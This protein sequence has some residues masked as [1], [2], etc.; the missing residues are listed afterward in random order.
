MEIKELFKSKLPQL[1]LDPE[2]LNFDDPQ[3]ELEDDE[4]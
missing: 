1:G 2:F 3:E 4:N